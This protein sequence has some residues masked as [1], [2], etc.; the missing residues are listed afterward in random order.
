M[1]TTTP[2]T[3][4]P[5]TTTGS[6]ASIT[7]SRG[8]QRRNIAITA[9]LCILLGG[10]TGWAVTSLLTPPQNPLASN[11]VTYAQAAPGQVEDTVLTGVL[12]SWQVSAGGQNQATGIVTGLKVQQGAE[13]SQG[14][15]LY[16]VNLRPTIAARGETPAFRAISAGA[17][18]ED[19]TQLQTMLQELGFFHGKIDG[20]VRW[21]TTAAI[22]AWQKGLGID[23]SGTVELGDVMFIPQLPA[24]I[25]IDSE[26][27]YRGATLAGG[28]EVIGT[29]DPTPTFTIP[30]TRKQATRIKD[31]ALVR[32]QGAEGSSWE[33]L[34]GEHKPEDERN[35]DGVTIELRSTGDAPI[36]GADCGKIPVTGENIYNADVVLLA[37]VKGITVPT[38]A[39]TTTPSGKAVVLDRKGKKHPVT[40]V[41]SAKGMSVVRGI[42]KGFTVRVPAAAGDTAGAG[43]NIAGGADAS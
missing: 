35:G 28:E 21:D 31:G 33:A 14:T 29:Y 40:V 39:I 15:P 18:G 2:P 5:G 24:R 32:I 4:E 20:V 16:T 8:K 3:T 22:R 10:A 1:A 9:L 12:A 17:E 19:V 13:I 36:C 37:A 38:A 42:R 41:A 11:Q 27:L 43:G 30:A 25:K 7:K 23:P 26:K 6:V 34:A